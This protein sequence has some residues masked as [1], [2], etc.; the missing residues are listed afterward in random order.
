MSSAGSAVVDFASDAGQAASDTIVE[1]VTLGTADTDTYNQV[2]TST[3]GTDTTGT[4]ATTTDTTTAVFYDMNG[5]A[6]S[7][8][9]AADAANAEILKAAG[10]AAMDDAVADFYAKEE[11]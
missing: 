9:A 10:P 7:T 11:S 4:T 3:S 1:I 5:V 8:Q 2:S 6:H